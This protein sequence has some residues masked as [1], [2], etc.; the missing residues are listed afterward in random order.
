MKDNTKPSE[1]AQNGICS[2]LIL[3]RFKTDLQKTTGVPK[4]VR[5]DMTEKEIS[6]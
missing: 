6:I 2:S 4:R 3:G 5:Q 1:A